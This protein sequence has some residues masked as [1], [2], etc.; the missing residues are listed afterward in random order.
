[1]LTGGV[2]TL[3]QSTP[4]SNWPKAGL[5]DDTCKYL[6]FHLAETLS[7]DRGSVPTLPICNDTFVS[8]S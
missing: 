5:F 1:M 8:M 2:G 4:T 3:P 7:A 6:G